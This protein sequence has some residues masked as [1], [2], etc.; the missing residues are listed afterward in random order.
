VEPAAPKNLLPE[1]Y[2]DQK[3]SGLTATVK[4]GDNSFDFPLE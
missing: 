2:A 3:T 4:E 1:K